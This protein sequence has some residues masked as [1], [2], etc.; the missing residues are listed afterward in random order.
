MVFGEDQQAFG[1]DT[2]GYFS[3][4]GFLGTRFPELETSGQGPVSSI[5]LACARPHFGPAADSRDQVPGRCGSMAPE[6]SR[7]CRFPAA[8]GLSGAPQIPGE[9]L[10]ASGVAWF[11]ESGP[12][13]IRPHVPTCATSPRPHREVRRDAGRQAPAPAG[14][15]QRC[16]WKA[17]PGTLVRQNEGNSGALELGGRVGCRLGV[18]DDE[19]DF[20]QLA[21]PDRGRACKFG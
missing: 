19:V 13:A 8:G 3:V 5:R 16:R 7:P 18:A 1:N 11:A 6:Q 2:I 9:K 12:A 17:P 21:Q 15:W 14:G 4:Q 10:A 20:G